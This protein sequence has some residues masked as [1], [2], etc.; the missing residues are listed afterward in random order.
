M[1]DR[2]TQGT[3][4]EMEKE[5]QTG[6]VTCLGMTFENDNARRAYFTNEL[7]KKLPELRKIEGFPDGDDERILALSDPPYYT[8]CPN[9]WI[10]DFILEWEQEKKN[11]QEEF[12]DY[13]REPFAT[14]VA[15]GKNE[16]IYNAHSYHT[17]VPHKAIMRYLLHYTQPG[18]IVF[19]GF[20]GTGMTGVASILCGDRQEVESLGFMVDQE[21]YI[22]NQ[23]ETDVSTNKFMRVGPRRALLNDLS[24][25]AS[26]ISYNYNSPWDSRIV[27]EANYLLQQYLNKTRWMYFTLKNSTDAESIAQKI[28]SYGNDVE[29]ITDGINQIKDLFVTVNYIVWSDVFQCPS[30]LH[31]IVYWEN[32]VD[33]ELRLQENFHCPKCT[34]A[35]SKKSMNRIYETVFDEITNQVVKR[36]KRKP[37][38]INYKEGT[39]SKNKKPD[40]FDIALINKIEKI[41]LQ[42]WVPRSEVPKGDKTGEVLKQ[43]ITHAHH[44]YTRRNLFVLSE[45]WEL[46][47][48]N[49]L[50]KLAL[51][52]VLTKTASILHNIGL[53]NGSINLAGAL[54]NAIYVPSNLAERNIFILLQGKI[55]DIIKSNPFRLQNNVISCMSS[56]SDITKV[57]GKKEFVDYI[58]IDPPFGANL[59]Y[60]ELNWLWEAW[61]DIFTENTTEAIENR[62]QEKNLQKYKHLMN[63]AFRGA[64]EIL[65]P[66]R[67]M[68]VEFS[69]THAS[70]WNAIQSAIKEA[71]FIIASVAALNKG[72]GTFNSQTNPTSVTQDLVISAYKPSNADLDNFKE[73]IQTNIHDSPWIFVEQYLSIIPLFRR[74]GQSSEIIIE[75]TPRII[76]DQMVAFFIQN[77]LAVPINSGDFQEQ[78]A[79]RYVLKDGMVFLPKQILEYDRKKMTVKDFVQQSLYISDESTAIEWLRQQLLK[80][81]QTR[82]DLQPNF[83]KEIQHIAKHEQLPELDALL[84]QNF[85]RYEG[86]E[87]VPSQIHTYLSSDYKDLRNLSKGDS[88][89][90]A[91]ARDRWY[92]PDPN[93]QADLE[94]LREKMLLREFAGYSDELSKHKKKL[95]Q[96]RTEAI[97]AGFKK[98]WG[99]KDYQTIVTI[100]ER[101]PENVL[102]ED[103]K[104]LMYYD[105][106]QIRLGL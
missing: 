80:K 25:I 15:E 100:G 50:L 86:K 77:G 7:K 84:E 2:L 20:S 13:S 6:P 11:L 43:H 48:R 99:E 22:Y 4:F 69:N 68:T 17:K 96:F 3:L 62:T 36:I 31:E 51:T 97:R 98:A 106:A 33:D 38:L 32:A 65:K 26:L 95:R 66:G 41:S 49:K 18:D 19:D 5:T 63:L 79:Q 40:A 30:C 89:L 85:L 93:K 23:G 74:N 105:N 58:F 42:N 27:D 59:M 103:D 24:P 35:V 91:K 53:K 21:G 28:D 54:P 82:Q 29:K 10:A 60:S 12:V 101:L 45:L 61:L 92:V 67:W 46:S 1:S 78:L 34:V 39:K 73:S 76:F 72:Q 81:P 83:M 8:I 37:V 57:I 47:K 87:D 56:A 9:P 16:A 52:A 88:E 71:G 94:K 44:F 75:R 14:D 55:S 64:Y 102:Q 104:L 70:V 90:K